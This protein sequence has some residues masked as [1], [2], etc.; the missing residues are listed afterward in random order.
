MSH[1]WFVAITKPRQEKVAKQQLENQSFSAYL[2]M[3]RR[4]KHRNG[5][6]KESCEALFPGYVFLQ[7]D[8]AKDDISPIRST[9]GVQG[10]VRFGNQLVALDQKVISRLQQNEQ[11]QLGGNVNHAAQFTAGDTVQM[12]SGPFAGLNGVFDISKSADRVI[13]L[14]GIL[15]GQQSVTIDVNNI[16]PA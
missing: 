10:L 13:V 5:K 16:A 12:L 8:L 6:W 1:G 11:Q 9:I 2:P 7:L 4:S 14:L 3:F 15:G